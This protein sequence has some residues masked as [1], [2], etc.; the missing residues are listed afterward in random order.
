MEALVWIL[1]GILLLDAIF[2]GWL[3]LVD[4]V[5]RHHERRDLRELDHLLRSVGA[6]PGRSPVKVRTSGAWSTPSV[7][8]G[9]GWAIPDEAPDAGPGE[10]LR[11]PGGRHA[12]DAR[13]LGARPAAGAVVVALVVLSAIVVSEPTSPSRQ[14]PAD[15]EG[16]P[17]AGGPLAAGPHGEPADRETDPTT[18]A[19]WEIPS[20]S[21][22]W[23]G[24]SV[25][26]KATSVP[27]AIAA[28]PSSSTA[29][30]LRWA[31]VPE[32]IGYL[33]Q[34]S[35]A[36]SSDWMPIASTGEAKTTYTDT[37]LESSTTYFYRIAAVVPDG[38]TPPSDIVSATTS[39]APPGATEVSASTSETSVTVTWANV[40]EETGYRIERSLGGTDDWL[41]IGT[42]GEDVTAYTDGGLSP[43]TTY[44]YRVVAMNAGGDSPPS[45]VVEATI[46]K[47]A[48]DA[49]GG[50]PP[51]PSNGSA[52]E[53][54]P[55]SGASELESVTPSPSPS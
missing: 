46:P 14:A 7:V 39:V 45:N 9:E 42:T 8:E 55:D 30:R 33:I 31:S 20:G 48:D 12:S 17:T 4:L 26:S 2:V 35:E 29:I 1:G 10:G 52:S 47:K 49:Q 5:G 38:P 28:Q 36:A 22:T 18:G 44:R 50:D 15:R 3:V 34:R 13:A 51:S 40:A 11:L 19:D 27:Q 43:G 53:A 32:A 54:P 16:T 37:G 21:F 25:T 23:P 24:P 6:S 41:T